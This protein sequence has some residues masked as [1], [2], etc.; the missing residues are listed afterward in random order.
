MDEQ[1]K[2]CC[3]TGKSC[4]NHKPIVVIIGILVLGTIVS[5][6]ILRDRIVN[7]QFRQVT[8]TGQGRVTYV[9]DIATINVGVQIDKVA[10]A[11][12]ALNQLNNRVKTITEAI[13]KL[14]VNESDITT[15]N[16]ALYTQYDF[17]D[18]IQVVAGYN[19]NQQ[20]LIRIKNL[21]DKKDLLNQVILE[22]SKAGANQINGVSFESSDM[23]NL[24]QQARILAIGDAQKKAGALAGAAGVQLKNIT[25]WYENLITNPGQPMMDYGKG[26]LGGA[27]GVSP[28]I[29]QAKNELVLE[30]G[31]SYSIK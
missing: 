11:D 26:G 19:A 1:N 24:K 12:E 30:I 8:V 25:G 21:K 28:S 13:K 9:P 10:K 15:N 7:P 20:L 4:C 23:E 3:G 2:D 16:Y 5:L 6:A 27:G 17:K 22:A 18:N 29:N 14:G 31:M